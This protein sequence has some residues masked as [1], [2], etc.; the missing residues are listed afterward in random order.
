MGHTGEW[1][2]A[3]ID[4]LGTG[5]HNTPTNNT[6]TTTSDSTARMM[7]DGRIG[8]DVELSGIGLHD[9]TASSSS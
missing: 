3:R 2:G 7:T 1:V 8:I 6:T 9:R 5:P 4:W